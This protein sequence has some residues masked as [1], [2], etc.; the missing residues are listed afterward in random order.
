MPP[1]LQGGSK[2]RTN[3]LLDA[4]LLQFFF[5]LFVRLV[6]RFIRRTIRRA[7]R[8]LQWVFALAVLNPDW[9]P[10]CDLARTPTNTPPPSPPQP[11]GEEDEKDEEDE[12]VEEVKNEPSLQWWRKDFF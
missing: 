5:V 12:E 9:P 8:L 1:S 10:G 4:W 7:T 6:A 2:F 11:E 3:W